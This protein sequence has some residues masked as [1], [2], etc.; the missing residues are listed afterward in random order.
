MVDKNAVSAATV[1]SRR[2]PSLFTS[3]IISRPVKTLRLRFAHLAA[4][5]GVLILGLGLSSANA[6]PPQPPQENQVYAN[7]EFDFELLKAAL[8]AFKKPE[9]DFDN[10]DLPFNADAIIII[11]RANPNG[12]QKIAE[13]IYSGVFVCRNEVSNLISEQISEGEGVGDPLNTIDILDTQN[14]F[15]LQYSPDSQPGNIKNRLCYSAREGT[16]CLI[17]ESK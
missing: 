17:L 5:G 4:I 7:C 9:Y 8:N 13:D 1:N 6:A 2:L 14:A 12:G 3:R 10:E 15:W 11:N 16:K